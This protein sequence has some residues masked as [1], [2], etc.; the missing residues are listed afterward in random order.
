MFGHWRWNLRRMKWDVDV[1]QH[2]W[3]DGVY[4]RGWR[5]VGMAR[6]GLMVH[7]S[8]L[9]MWIRRRLEITKA[10]LALNR[11]FGKGF[12]GRVITFWV[13]NVEQ[14]IG[15]VAAMDA[16]IIS[17]TSIALL[18]MW[19]T[20]CTFQVAGGTVTAL[21]IDTE[22]IFTARRRNWCSWNKSEQW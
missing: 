18:L 12:I 17:Q 22:G 15:P 8:L 4:R 20:V 9:D 2:M 21:W 16:F 14:L 3:W 7:R 13:A 19:F 10:T 1:L 5:I 6:N 11:H